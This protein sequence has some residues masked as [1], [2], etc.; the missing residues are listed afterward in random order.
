M[1]GEIECGIQ[2]CTSEYS[3]QQAGYGQAQVVHPARTGYE[4]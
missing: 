2:V 4:L 3:P 1:G